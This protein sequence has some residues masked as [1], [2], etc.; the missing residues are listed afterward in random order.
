MVRHVYSGSHRVR[1]PERNKMADAAETKQLSIECLVQ[2]IRFV[3]HLTV[4]L[5]SFTVAS[6]VEACKLLM[7][8]V[9][10][11]PQQQKTSYRLEVTRDRDTWSAT[12]KFDITAYYHHFMSFKQNQ[13]KIDEV[14]RYINHVLQ[15]GP[16][17][18]RELDIPHEDPIIPQ[19][20]RECKYGHQCY[21]ITSHGKV[22]CPQNVDHSSHINMCQASV[23]TSD[24]KPRQC[25][26]RIHESSIIKPL[27]ARVSKKGYV[28]TIRPDGC[29]DLLLMPRI[30]LD[31]GQAHANTNLVKT[32][33]MWHAAL[34]VKKQL[35][36][37]AGSTNVVVGFA[38]NFGKW[39]SA[40][41]RDEHLLECHG[42]THIYLS[43]DAA[44]KLSKMPGYSETMKGHTRFWITEDHYFRDCRSLLAMYLTN[45]QI[46]SL[47]QDVQ[48]LTTDFKTFG[49]E[50]KT[51]KDEFKT[52]KDILFD[53]IQESRAARPRNET[54]QTEQEPSDQ[55]QDGHQES[56]TTATGTVT[57]KKSKKK[58]ST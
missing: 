3:P 31:Q 56:I 58:K 32:Q 9:E 26:F 52:F 10:K 37:D 44:M 57:K 46:R 33:H 11:V 41:H 1:V 24:G 45:H 5:P 16:E 53:F 6:I 7:D 27:T 54:T 18:D 8:A 20:S 43:L 28:V 47:R 38:V 29:R 23:K 50:F 30:P 19:V 12:L 39:E 14:E 49:N 22:K 21:S 15:M 36:Q 17:C 51:F 25:D 13:N 40:V 42:H 55:K 48:Q 34:A 2:P 4:S 35:E